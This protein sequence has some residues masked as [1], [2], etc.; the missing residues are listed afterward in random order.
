MTQPT[1]AIKKLYPNATVPV[2]AHPT[3]AGADLTA[4]KECTL[5]P[6]ETVLVPTGIALAIPQGF[7]GQVRPRSGLAFKHQVTV[8]NSP[9][10]I[11]SGYRGEVGV[12]LINHGKQPFV[13][14]VG[15][16]IAQLVIAPVTQA[17]F[18]LMGDLDD[19]PRASGGFGST[20]A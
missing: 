11:D 9:G 14:T 18:T 13:V 1:I 5:Q 16:G 12:I 7:E 2:Y 15:M 8:L 6:G 19:T 20:G 3:D 17:Q 4:V 10:T